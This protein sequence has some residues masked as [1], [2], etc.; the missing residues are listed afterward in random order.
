M[1]DEVDGD[2]EAGEVYLPGHLSHLTW[3]TF[4]PMSARVMST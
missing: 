4:F 2:R 3:E 1:G